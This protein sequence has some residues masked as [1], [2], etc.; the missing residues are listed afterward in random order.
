M[1]PEPDDTEPKTNIQRLRKLRRCS[2]DYL[3]NQ[4]DGINLDVD[5]T[6]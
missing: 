1:L 5:S 4:I 2:K 6:L 3:S